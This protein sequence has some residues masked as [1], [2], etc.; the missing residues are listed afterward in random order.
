MAEAGEGTE[1][2][3][4]IEHPS[5]ET[6]VVATL[7]AGGAVQRAAILRTARKLFDGQVFANSITQPR[8]ANDR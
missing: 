1:R 6:T 7:D 3:L 2:S 8:H 5:G 4:S